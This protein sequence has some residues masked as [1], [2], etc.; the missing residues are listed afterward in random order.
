MHI[1]YEIFTK[2]LTCRFHVLISC[3]IIS[4]RVGS[5]SERSFNLENWRSLDTNNQIFA[6]P[7]AIISCQ[8]AGNWFSVQIN[9]RYRSLIINIYIYISFKIFDFIYLQIKFANLSKF[10]TSF[11]SSNTFQRTAISPLV[12]RNPKSFWHNSN[13]LYLYIAIYIW[14]STASTLGMDFHDQETAIVARLKRRGGVVKVFAAAGVENRVLRLIGSSITQMR[15]TLW[16][17]WGARAHKIA[18][19]SRQARETL[20]I[21]RSLSAGRLLEV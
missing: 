20:S 4:K 21:S 19:P 13:I 17:E 2:F 12:L 10:I 16:R 6:G 1:S 5:I 11:R 8:T 7:F 3:D 9:R 18:L 14:P 15:R